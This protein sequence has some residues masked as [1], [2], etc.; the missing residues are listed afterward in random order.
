MCEE[1]N[2]TRSAG[3]FKIYDHLTDLPDAEDIAPSSLTEWRNDKLLKILSLSWIVKP[4]KEH[5]NNVFLPIQLQLGS[6]KGNNMKSRFNLY[7]RAK[8]VGTAKYTSERMLTI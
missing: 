3:A 4:S 6:E 2:K 7:L 8:W 5:N 1:A